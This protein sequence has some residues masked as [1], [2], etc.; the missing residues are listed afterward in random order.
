M[1]LVT[2]GFLHFSFIDILDVLFVAVIL[3]M[4]FRRIRGTSAMNIF[5]AILILLIIRIIAG[6]LDMKM[7]SSLVGTLLDVG[8]I[9]LIVIFQPEI[10]RFLTR[11]GRTAEL[12]GG[13]LGFLDHILGRDD[14]TAV[15]DENIDKIASACKQMGE[16]KIGAL[17]V[18]TNKDPLDDIAATGDV[19]D[20][21]INKR[22]IINIFFKNS[23]L[24]DGAMIIE[25]G[26]IRAARCTLPITA[27]SDISARYGM[28]HKAAIGISEI[29]D[30]DVI[31][32]SEE[33]GEIS[34]VQNGK[35]RTIENINT[36]KLLLG[37]KEYDK[38]E[39]GV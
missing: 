24:H 21:Q 13:G 23:P 18:L 20:A 27:R 36:L 17:I 9:A 28:R 32:V 35:M 4:V 39:T 38:P 37:S 19:V 31:V 34:F 16:R 30:A 26:R 25:G 6:A 2:I 12:R 29:C 14:Q 5:V 33:S 15:G 8:V 22:L 3:Y 11:L 10:R 7:M 1:I